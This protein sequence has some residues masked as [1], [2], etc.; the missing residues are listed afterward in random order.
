MP[1][2][3]DNIE[4]HLEEGLNKTLETSFRADFCIG[5]FNLRGWKKIAEN[6]DQLKGGV[7]PD[8]FEDDTHYHTRVLIG[9]QRL[10]Q[11]EIRQFYSVDFG[12]L[13]NAEA[14][15]LKSKIAA[16]FKEQLIIG[17]PTNEDEK[18]LKKLLDQL[19][20]KKVIVK[21]H[22]KKTLHAKLY[23]AHR[24][25]YNT[26]LVG[27]VGSS[28]LTF[29]G[30]SKQFE[31]NVDVVEGDAANKLAKWFQDRWDDR[32]SIDI[33]EEL[34]EILENSWASTQLIPPYHIY[35][36]MAY[37]LSR[38]ARAGIS[39]FQLPKV[40]QDRLLAYQQSAVK[41]AA[42]HLHHRGGVIIG[43]VVG[44]GKTITATAL[45]KMFEDDFFLET[46]IICPKNLVEMWEDYAHEYQLR[47]KVLSVT[48]A[49]T[50]LSDERRYRL[51]IIDESH[52][53]RNKD[54]KRYRAIQEYI[55]LNDSK[56]ILLTAT[57]YNKTYL[58]LSNQLRLFLDEDYNLGI[59]PERYIENIGGRVEFQANHQVPEHSV[60]AFEKSSFSDD[61]AELMR[62]F[63]VR[64]TR[65]FIKSNYA[66]NDPAKNRA[67]LEFPNG[68]RSYFPDRLPRKVEY[69]FDKNDPE[70]QYAKLYSQSVVDIIDNLVLPRY[71]IG[72]TSYEE[73]NPSI[74]ITAEESL[75]REN[76]SRAGTRLIGFARTNL[77][78]RL[79]SSGYS[80]LLSVSRHILRNYLFIYAI[81]KG[82]RFPIGKQESGLIDDFMYSDEDPNGDDK[83]DL[84]LTPEEYMKQAESYYKSLLL[85]EKK[86]DWIRSEHFNKKLRKTLEQD[87]TE[88]MK[89][90]EMGKNWSQSEDRQLQALFDLI[91][92]KH[93]NE[94]ILIFTQFSD[95]ANYLYESL[96]ARG[97]EKIAC[98]TGADENPTG[99]AHRFSPVSNKKD[100]PES[101]QI[102]VLITTD[103]LSEG[104][105]LQDAH[106]VLNYD[107]PWA[108]IRLIQR[109]GR[110]DRIGQ[111]HDQ[112]FCY[113]FLPEDG[114]EDIINLR[115]RL[116]Q[117][118]RENAETVGSDE[119]FFDGDPINV[120]DLYNEKSGILDEDEDIEVDLASYAF[121]IWK[122][123][124]D[125]DPSLL[126]LIPDLPDVIYSAKKAEPDQKLNGSIVYT[127]TSSDN[128]V[129]AWVDQNKNIV[130]QSQ[131][132]ILKSVKCGP[133][134]PALDRFDQ[135]HELVKFGLEHIKDTESKIGGQL[136]KKSGARYRAYNRLNNYITRNEGTLWVTDELKRAIQDIYDY[137][138][139][140]YARETINR[141]LKMGVTDEDL[142][143]LVVSLREDGKLS[144]INEDELV[145]KDPLIICSLGLKVD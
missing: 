80:F 16:E 6:V 19:K 27:F 124:T 113:S 2:I 137:P 52:N 14:K 99:F 120:A 82:L 62:L 24:E 26:P 11:E 45:A 37:H 125:S 15:R 127:K 132:E 105:N 75:I 63:L 1:T 102:R 109:A 69:A 73:K 100:F 134:E 78:K 87:S 139:R 55:Q 61:W 144:I 74:N 145:R 83:I 90:L 49:Q 130:T 86:Y 42:H 58:D 135:H 48:K 67:Y 22:L 70:D 92:D 81:E 93:S 77:F 44:L 17:N 21:L 101:Q 34:I 51:V 121:Q 43:D 3:Y 41:V 138:M 111:K 97:I 57:P 54:G 122:N 32:W 123:A 56:V 60:G 103:V 10:P 140:E 40:F 18:A 71:G 33:T 35:L 108:I 38:E 96:H 126:K 9:M 76:L 68:D 107:L 31:L 8:E 66:K 95:T 84:M 94:K 65:S 13:D 116:T 89:I 112:I 98:V 79:E 4:N 39:E 5:Y 136:G 7:L 104:Q 36:K 128:D 85:K 106:I 117:R 25:D 143:M 114:I 47:A 53:L 88:L 64:R 23:L 29:A 28:N 59:G 20:S 129:L 119:V 133:A 30:I 142:A 131:F 141:Q 110:V 72:Q 50:K 118:I 12:N 115:G 91:N 46:L